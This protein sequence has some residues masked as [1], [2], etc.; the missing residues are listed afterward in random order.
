[1]NFRSSRGTATISDI[2]FTASGPVSTLMRLAGH[3]EFARHE[4]AQ[5]LRHLAVELDADHR[6]A[7]AAFQRCLEQLDQI[8]RLF[9]DLD[10]AVADDAECSGTLDLVTREQL[11][12]EQADRLL[13]RNEAHIRLAVGQPDE[14]PQRRRQAQ[15]RRHALR[16]P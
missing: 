16:R 11:A 2:W 5:F 12:D 7:A 3:T 13:D 9:L 1:M 8:L 4:V 10:I 6:T 15:Q 14:T